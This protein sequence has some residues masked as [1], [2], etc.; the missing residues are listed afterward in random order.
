VA[1]D[2]I[3]PDEVAKRAMELAARAEELARHAHETADI[4]EQLARLEAELDALDAEHLRVAGASADT[5]TGADADAAAGSDETAFGWAD[6]LTDRVGSLGDRLGTFIEQVTDAALRS[7]HVSVGVERDH[8]EQRTVV[9][10]KGGIVQV[11]SDGGSVSVHVH[12]RDEVTVVARGSKAAPPSVVRLEQNGRT[13]RVICRGPRAWRARGIHLDIAVPAE[14]EVAVTTGG[15]AVAIQGVG[16]PAE[17][18]TG[19]GSISVSGMRRS[20]DLT[21]GGGSI[22]LTDVDGSVTAR[23]G[24]GGIRIEGRLTGSSTVRTGGGSIVVRP[25]PTTRIRVD[26]RGT[27]A[28]TDLDGLSAERGRITGSLGGG[29]DGELRAGTGGGTIR[30]VS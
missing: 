8:V 27:R 12:D 24:G 9:A 25:D 7:A 29:E 17:V 13:V 19:G 20:A 21:T 4:D 15:G 11:N 30:I 26:G 2:A 22:E 10:A 28:Y 16:G 5:D 14:S 18:R 1:E 23:T 3:T 6:H